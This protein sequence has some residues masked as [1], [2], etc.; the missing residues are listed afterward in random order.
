MDEKKKNRKEWIKTAA[1]IF[2][3]VMLVLTFFSNTIMNYSLPQVA[4]EYVQNQSITAKIRGT[5]TVSASDPYELKGTDTRVISSVKVQKGDEVQK[6]DVI[7]ELEDKE[8]DELKKAKESLEALELEFNKAILTDEVTANTLNKI[9]D[10]KLESLSTMQSELAAAKGAADG[11]KDK[12]Q[13]AQETVDSLTKQVSALEYNT[14]DTSAEKEAVEN[15]K[16][17]VQNAEAQVADFQA[18]YDSADS[19]KKAADSNLAAKQ[20]AFDNAIKN[21]LANCDTKDKELEDANK[22]RSEVYA[23]PTATDEDK[24]NVDNLVEEAQKAKDAAY[25]QLGK[26]DQDALK[27][28]L[29]AAKKEADNANGV[30]AN[31]ER[32]LNSAKQNKANADNVLAQAKANL[33]KKEENGTASSTQQEQSL[34]KQLLDANDALEK[35]K[36]A[37]EEAETKYTD[38]QKKLLSEIGVDSQYQALIDAREEVKKLEEEASE[39]AILAPVSGTI[40]NITKVAGESTAPDTTLVTILPSGKEKTL[41]I[42]VTNEQAKKVNVGAVGEIA[43]AWYYSDVVLK[44]I[45][46]KTDQDQPSTNK[47]LTFS[48]EG[49]VSDGQN[50]NISVGDKSSNY[51]YVVPNSAIREDKK[52][53][54]ILIVKSKSSPLGNRYFATR[55]DVEVLASDEKNTAVKGDVEAYDYVITT[56]SKPVEAGNQVRLYD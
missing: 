50:L 49:D 20:D 41:S 8:S 45:S 15:A 7:F 51:D 3:S 9:E 13:K 46:I 28:D 29:N 56:A 25:A 24:K 4:T 26:I 22:K 35:A 5:G 42:S 36:K 14:I 39:S 16:N 19:T 40:S 53:K 30:F 38:M 48:V 31:A 2:L 37:Q 34:K 47:K 54:F 33:E 27:K 11:A 32:D 23:D 18:K 10:G 1:I 21:A 43:D 6:G 44:L 55:V 52:G 17:A 12:T